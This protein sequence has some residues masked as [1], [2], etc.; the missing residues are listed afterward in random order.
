MPKKATIITFHC[1]P[2]YGAVLQA[3]ALQEKLKDYFTHVELLDYTPE[4]ITKDYR[5]ISVYSLASVVTSLWSLA[6]HVRKKKAFR[7]FSQTRLQLSDM[8]G[9][10]GEKFTGYTTDYLFLGSDQIWN[11]QITG[12]FD[13]MYFGKF[14]YS[15]QPYVISYAASLGK[16]ALGVRE[17]AE[18][19][20]L[21][22]EVDCV[23]VRE[24]E[25]QL[26]LQKQIGVHSELAVDPTILVGV[27]LF[28]SL[29]RPVK[30]EQ[31]LFLYSLNGYSETDALA[32]KVARYLGLPIVEVSGRRKPI[33]PQKHTA[34]YDAGPEEFLSLLCH[35]KF[36][37][38]DSFH[39]TV[40]SLL[41]HRMFLAIPHK[42]RG[43]RLINLLDLVGIPER[44]TTRFDRELV[45]DDIAWAAV[46]QRLAAERGKS[47]AFIRRAVADI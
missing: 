17:N 34:I 3:Y 13:P 23:S 31:Y 32:E 30:Y 33:V 24:R 10:C 38:T 21:L 22:N 4:S 9:R 46:D 47:E 26:L 45:L 6:P 2:N 28:Q 37:V 8:S 29:I 43:G 40:F 15:G 5:N 14:A 41:F 36:V 20:A 27:D 1:V 12:G 11:S 35:A 39:G 42:T 7:K 44:L 18:L 16:N 19:H 25:A